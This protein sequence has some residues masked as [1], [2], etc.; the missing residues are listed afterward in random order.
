[1]SQ[2]QVSQSIVISSGDILWQNDHEVVIYQHGIQQEGTQQEG[3][4]EQGTQEQG[5][6]VLLKVVPMS[7]SNFLGT[8]RE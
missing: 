1:V 7:S 2:S 4:Q 3:R 8:S 5:R 6:L